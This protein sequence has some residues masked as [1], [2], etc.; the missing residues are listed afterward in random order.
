MKK[1]LLALAAL[2]AF[3]GVASAQSSVT[4][5]GVVDMNVR[6]VKNG[7]NDMKSLSTNGLATSRLGFRGT[8]DLG[9]G[10]KAQFWLEGQL[11]PDTG[12]T[13]QNWQRRSTLGL[14]GSFGEIRL[15]RDYTPTWNSLSAFDPFGTN[16]LGSS[17]NLYEDRDGGGVMNSGATTRVRVNNA[18][19]Y[20]LPTMGGLFGQL[21]VAAGEGVAGNKY[22]G[23]MLGYASGP[24]RVSAAWGKTEIN[25][26][27]D[28]VGMNVGATFNVGFA[29]I[30]GLWI[31]HEV[32]GPTPASD[33]DQT[34]YLLGLTI[35]VGAGTIKASYG[36]AKA[37]GTAYDGKQIA[38]GYVYDL[39]KRT[40]LYTTYS[41]IDNKNGARYTVAPWS[42]GT[43]NGS[44]AFGGSDNSPKSKGFEVGIRHAF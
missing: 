4:L 36:Q 12:G 3:A 20:F 18:V 9:G 34:N 37:D 15:G 13:G 25:G 32:D 42:A 41:Q 40:A 8:E 28:L 23:G 5:F 26:T 1:S 19:S 10:M 38:I 33:I 14:L 6:Q 39:S 22:F 21:Q 2:T 11:D 35:P 44:P 29:T 31:K 7:S 24:F 43:N 27:T 30:W 16:G 17:A